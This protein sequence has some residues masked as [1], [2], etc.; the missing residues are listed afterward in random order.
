MAAVI[1]LDTHVVAWLYGS[2]TE[3]LSPEAVRMLQ[4]ADELRVSPMVRL[5][6]QYLFE[7]GRVT[8]TA[9]VVV[10]ELATTLGL[11][12]C[13][14]PFA[15]VGV[16]AERHDFTRDPFDRL[17]VAQAAVVDAPLLTRDETIREAY[18]KARW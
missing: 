16:E 14:R 18:A 11:I 7:I 9:A 1:Y 13:D 6:L 5:E 3:L 8:T 4:S 17:I 10:D 12:V 15:E 2:G